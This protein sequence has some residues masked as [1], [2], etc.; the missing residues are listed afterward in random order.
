MVNVVVQET[1]RKGK[2]LFA[3]DAI[4]KDEQ[5]GEYTGERISKEDAD[6]R[7]GDLVWFFMVDEE[8]YIDAEHDACLVKYVNH[9][10]DPNCESDVVDGRVFYTALRDIAP[11]EEL[12][13]DY[14]LE[15]DEGDD[16]PYE[17]HC[18]ASN[19]R[20]TMKDTKKEEE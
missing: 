12:T 14:A 19:C 5:I 16:D 11:G 8:T 6:G 15:V 17:C 20:G 4:K 1:P 10:C 2:G 9:S 18:G 3:V 7:Q 13:V